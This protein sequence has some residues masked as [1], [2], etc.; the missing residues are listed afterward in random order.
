MNKTILYVLVLT[1]GIVSMSLA[2]EETWTKKADMPIATSLHSASVVDDKIY[3]IGG[4]DNIYGWSDYWS[5]VWEYDPATDT[6]TRKADMSPG[7]ARLSA[8]VVD[9][10]IYAIGGSPHRDSEVPTVEMYD[11]TTDTWTRKTDM[12]RA[13]NFLSSSVVNGKIYTIGGKIYPSETMVS[14]VEMYDPAMDTWTRKADMPTARGMHSASVVDDKIYVIGGVTGAYGPWIS[15]VEMYDPATDTWIRKANMPTVRSSHSSSVLNG[16]IYAIGGGYTWDY[17]TPKVE[18]YDPSTN[19]WTRGL[20]MPTARACHSASVVNGKIYTIGGILDASSWT[21]VPTVEVYDP[22]PLVLDFNGDEIVDSADM[23]LMIDY[24][25]TNEP[26]YDI[27]PP[28]FGDGIVD[29]QDLILL[30]EHLFEEIFPSELVAYWKLDEQE[31]DIANNSISDNHGI[32]SGNPTW[33]PNNGLLA[34]AIEF[35]GIDDYISTNFVLDP[36]LGTFSVFA[37]IKSSV[38]G[39]VIISQADGVGTGET[40]LCIDMSNGNLITD[41]LPQKIGRYYPEPLISE[42]FI[43]DGLWHYIGLVWDGSYRILYADGIEVAKDTAVRVPPKSATGGIYIGADKNIN[44]E[45]L[46]SGLID[47][48]RI[49]NVALSAEEIVTLSK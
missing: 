32:L 34:G 4:T 47:D 10:K 9:G 16:K 45:T 17:C 38:T 25:G 48:V 1:N 18:V 20:N 7:R 29:V 2:A 42:F 11:P 27:A 26:L 44:T 12:P 23:C 43:S 46:F 21:T 41:L 35:D 28:P 24:W 49:Y 22:N 8:C 39:Q 36:S 30:A 5:N 19:T 31:G 6:W 14:T 3:I 33:Q 13:R 15:T 40:W 37:W